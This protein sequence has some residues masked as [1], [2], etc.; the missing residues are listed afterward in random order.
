MSASI[1]YTSQF[2]HKDWIDFVDSVQAGGTN[3]INGR[4]HAIEAE[5][6]KTFGGDRP[7]QRRPRNSAPDGVADFRA[8]LAPN[9]AGVSVGS[10]QRDRSKGRRS[11]GRR[12]LD[13]TAVAGWRPAAD[14]HHHRQ[15]ERQLSGLSTSSWRGKRSPEGRSSLCLRF[16]WP[17]SRIHF[18]SRDGAATQPGR[19]QRQ[20]IPGDRQDRRRRRRGHR[21]AD[22]NPNRMQTLVK[23]RRPAHP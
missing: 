9:A 21:L 19:Q 4:M 15:Q 12:R 8:G 16:R 10:E 5:F 13:A 1:S 7:D 17:T 14:H 6:D 22:R 23:E 2:S 20:Q 11:N 18:S 3:G